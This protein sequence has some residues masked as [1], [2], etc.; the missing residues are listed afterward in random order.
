MRVH[1]VQLSVDL[2]EPVPDRVDRVSGLVR[3]QRGAD[4]VLLPELW[5]QGAF[6]FPTFAQTAQALDGPAVRALREAARDIGAWLHGGSFVERDADGAL[7]N[8]A[9]LIRPDGEVAATYRKIH[10]FGFDG[11][12]T[13]VLTP[14][15]ELVTADVDGTTVGLAT[16]YDLRFPELFRALVDR[17]A[18]VFLLPAAWPAPRVA[19]WRL[20]AQARAVEEQA[21]VVAGNTAGEQGGLRMGGGSLVVD[22]WG[23]IVAE[24]GDGEEVLVAD[25][26]PDLVT[27]TRADFPVLP[28]RRL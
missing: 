19:H 2:A 6:A 28:D 15:T 13:T 17:G 26:D 21:Y 20:L 12:E 27:R 16:C 4:L 1:V 24:A 10:L 14:G 23:V 22:P 25:V 3:A 11:G 18:Q 9:V 5:V 7:H 8:T